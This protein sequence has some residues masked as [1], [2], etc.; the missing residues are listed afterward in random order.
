MRELEA[1]DMLTSRAG[2]ANGSGMKKE[3]DKLVAQNLQRRL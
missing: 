2:R 3:L 1:L